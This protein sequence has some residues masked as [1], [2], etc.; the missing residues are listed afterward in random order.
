MRHG[1][2]AGL[3]VDRLSPLSL[4]ANCDS[5]GLIPLALP[6]RVPNHVP[7]SANMTPPKLT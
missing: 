6:N 3:Q 7:S 5:D 4:R 1:T 2:L